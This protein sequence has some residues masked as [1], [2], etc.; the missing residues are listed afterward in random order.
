MLYGEGA[1]S[2]PQ[3]MEV[4][5]NLLTLVLPFHH[6]GPRDGAGWWLVLLTAELSSELFICILSY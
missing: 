3:C 5:N 6:G 1:V 4:E 2:T